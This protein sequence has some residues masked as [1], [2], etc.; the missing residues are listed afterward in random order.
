MSSAFWRCSAGQ[1]FGLDGPI[2]EDP[3][4]NWI[5]PFHTAN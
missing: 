2:I 5:E 3:C 4:S 1:L